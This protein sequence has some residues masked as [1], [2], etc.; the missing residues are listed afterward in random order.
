MSIREVPRPMT[1]VT[2]MLPPQPVLSLPARAPGSGQ[3]AENRA[4]SVLGQDTAAFST[5]IAP[6]PHKRS[7]FEKLLSPYLNYAASLGAKKF[8]HSART[9][10]EVTP[11]QLG[12][13]ATPLSFTSRDGKT[14]L[15]GYYM[16]ADKPTDRTVVLAHGWGGQQGAE[17]K[18]FAKWLHDAGYNVLSFD[19]RNSGGSGGTQCT[20]GYEEQ[21]DLQAAIDQAVGKGAKRIAVMGRSMGGATAIELAARDPRIN[22]IVDDCAFDTI[23][24]AIEPRV[25][26][27]RQQVG[28]F[29]IPY[30]FPHL[31]ATAIA[32][33]VDRDANEPVAESNP[34]DAIKKL[35]DRPILIIHGAADDETLPEDSQHLYDAD[36]GQNKELWLVPK[37]THGQS[38][39][40]DP[41][42]YRD[43]VLRF[44]NINL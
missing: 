39:D 40:T 32:E 36:P 27:E 30:P 41:R 1:F 14:P 20:M 28:P 34:I 3:P 38:Y 2:P 25:E 11:T 22:T 18:R 17:L 31:A 42:G 24:D 6:P 5:A 19:F 12:L 37:A 21:W 16:P 7:F 44:L 29:K 26:R 33:Q 8:M 13:A 10:D 23:Y 4:T 43:R 9:A 35:G 15:V